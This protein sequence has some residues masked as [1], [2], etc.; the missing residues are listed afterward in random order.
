MPDIENAVKLLTTWCRKAPPSQV[1]LIFKSAAATVLLGNIVQQ[2]PGSDIDKPLRTLFTLL[3]RTPSSD[4][5]QVQ[6]GSA[7]ASAM[8]SAVRAVINKLAASAGDSSDTAYRTSLAKAVAAVAK[9]LGATAGGFRS[10]LR[11]LTGTPAEEEALARASSLAAADLATLELEAQRLVSANGLPRS[12]KEPVQGSLAPTNSA[13]LRVLVQQR[14]VTVVM[15]DA[16]LERLAATASASSDA[17]VA[18]VVAPE[19]DAQAF[20]AALSPLS[21]HADEGADKSVS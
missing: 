8:V 5:E 21:G 6:A 16:A 3:F 19:G 4:E 11:A 17:P 15:V 10:Q 20:V 13:E 9:R 12:Y 14:D 18:P 2:L 7:A 1:D